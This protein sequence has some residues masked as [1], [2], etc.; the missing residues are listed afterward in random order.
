MAYLT[1]EELSTHIYEGVVNEITREDDTI[2][3]AAIDAAIGEARGYLTPRYDVAAIFASEGSNRDPVLFLYIKDCA[4]WHFISLANPNI[5]LALAQIRYERAIKWLREVQAGIT[6]P[7]G[8][9]VP[10]IESDGTNPK[11]GIQ[12]KSNLKR[13]NQF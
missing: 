4:K 6:N 10:S 9:P 8:L 5:D 13:D 12:W 11:T 1:I 3:Q 7:F 2:A